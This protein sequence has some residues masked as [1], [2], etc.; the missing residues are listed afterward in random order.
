MRESEVRVAIV[1]FGLGNI[2]NVKRAC[3]HVGIGAFLTTNATDVLAADAVILPGVGAMPEAMRALQA[4]GLDDAIRR[5]AGDGKP[6]LGVC[7]GL[8]LLMTSGTEFSDHD[9]LGIFPGRVERFP[10]KT[11]DG[12]VL[13]VPHIGWTSIYPVRQ[14]SWQ[15]TLLSS[16]PAGSSMYFVHSY[17][18]IPED[19]GI[20]LANARHTGIEFVAA[21]SSGSIFACQFHPERSGPD[22]LRIYREF[23]ARLG[24]PA[25]EMGI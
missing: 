2:H 13:R 7:L 18:A 14:G 21:V 24:T 19:P 9:G 3:A 12:A 5:V 1:D 15:D 8:Q 25:V 22:G 11:S 10:R 16:T 20:V 23:A 6:L 4:T 17:H